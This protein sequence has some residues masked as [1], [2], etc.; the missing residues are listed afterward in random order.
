MVMESSTEPRF[1]P[2]VAA[3]IFLELAN[4]HSLQGALQKVFAM[5]GERSLLSCLQIWRIEDGDRCLRCPLQDKCADHRRCL[6]LTAGRGVSVVEGAEA[7]SYF[8]DP[9]A[10]IP[11][12]YGLL[13]QVASERKTSILPKMT[14]ADH[15]AVGVEWT[16]PEQIRALGIA[17]IVFKGEILGVL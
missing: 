7:V 6:H 15:E 12:G 17:P 13:G 1:D 14:A 3:R 8:G 11:M 10:R 9:N 2:N 4:E 16:Q 5:M